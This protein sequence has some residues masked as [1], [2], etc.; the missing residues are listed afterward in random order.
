MSAAQH[1][2]WLNL[3]EKTG[4]FLAVGVLDEAF[5]QGLEKVETRRRQRVRSAYDEWRDAV[6]DGDPQ[7]DGLHREWVRLV[8]E[9]LLEYEPS[10]LKPTSALPATLTYLESLTGAEVKPDFAVLS[11]DKARLLITRYATDTDLSA[12]LAG[13]TWAASPIERMTTLCRATG[14]RVGLITDGEQWTLVSVPA[15]GGSSLGTWYARIWLQEPVTLQAFVSLLEVRRCFGPAEVNL[16]SL[17]LRSLEHQDEVTDT[18][19][20]QV[21]RA[22]E[23]LVQAL[24]R[25]DLD[26]DRE[27]LKDVSP[28]Q[29]YEAGLTVM[30]R[31]VVLLCAEERKL[32]LLGEPIYDQ[33]YAVSTLRARL[34]KDKER[35]G[36]EVLE[37]RHDAWSRLLAVFRAVF[38]GIEHETLRLPPLGGSLFDPDRFPFLEGRATGTSW[39][40]VPAVPLPIDNRTVLMLLTAL[41]VL[42]QRSGA[43]LLSYEALDVEQIGH[44]YEG[45]LERTV[46]R[47]PETTLGLI[48]SQ[49]AINPTIALRELEETKAKGDDKLLTYLL[50]HTGRSESGLKR[51]LT[52]TVDEPLYHRLLL[53]C[54]SDVPL[55]D[56]IKQWSTLVRTDSWGDPLVYRQDA[57]IVTLGAGRRE[58]GTH[59][60]PKSLTEPIVQHT[61]EPL[62]YVGPAEGKPR[63]EWKLKSP[64]QLL[65]LKVC[66]MAM[67][68]GAFLVQTCRWLGE[69]LVEAWDAEEKA[70]RA[71]SIEGVVLAQAGDA[72]PLP[73]DPAERVLIARRLI[74]SRCLYGVDINP[75][76]VELAKLSLWLITMMRNRPFSFLDHALKCGNSLLGIS[77]INQLKNFSLRPGDKQMT[78]ATAN[79]VRYVEEA[80]A[81]RRTLE[82]LPSND[83]AQIEAKQRLHLEAEGA[84]SKVKALANALIAFELRGLNGNE[85][86]EQRAVAAVS[87]ATA[88]Q[89]PLGEAGI[90]SG[91]PTEIL[92]AFHW[93]IEFPEVFLDGGF[94]FTVGNPP[95][96]S[97]HSRQSHKE[98]S[99]FAKRLACCYRFPQSPLASKRLNSAM[100]FWERATDITSPAGHIGLLNDLNLLEEN[101]AVVREALVRH[102]SIL[103]VVPNIKAFK[104]VASGQVFLS[105]KNRPPDSSWKYSIAEGWIEGDR[106][107]QS[108][109]SASNNYD[110]IGSSRSITINGRQLSELCI[111]NT[112]VNLSGAADDFLTDT[113]SSQFSQRFI[114]S[115]AIQSK[116]QS[117][118][119]PTGCI[120]FSEK[121]CEEVN[122]AFRDRG[123]K[124]VAVL[125]KLQ[126]FTGEKIIVRQSASEIIATMDS[127]G[128]VCSYSFFVINKRS[129]CPYD[130]WYILGVLNSRRLTDYAV[131]AGIIKMAAGKQPQIRK[132]GLDSLPIPTPQDENLMSLV[133]V[134]ARKLTQEH[135]EAVRTD[136]F[137]E[138]NRLVEDCF[139]KHSDESVC[140]TT[141]E[142][143]RELELAKVTPPPTRGNPKDKSC[144]PG[145]SSGDVEQSDLL[146]AIFT[147]AARREITDREDLARQVAETLGFQRLT[148]NLREVIASGINSAIRRGLVNYDAQTIHRVAASYAELDHDFLVKAINASIRPGCVY[149]P[150]EVLHLAADYL[151]CKRLKDAFS[152]RLESALTAASLR[153]I[154]IKRGEEIRKAE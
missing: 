100:F 3:V 116:F 53:A 135:D 31:L 36:E 112:G 51:A 122:Q 126:R 29:L 57:F 48:G 149:T 72:E 11:G 28:A 118:I 150:E 67:G 30:M 17:F 83:H 151:G 141:Q 101:F 105:V 139:S 140:E 59:Y 134:L 123:S 77:S 90:V 37:R 107:L 76:A 115:K 62:A 70:G 21:R 106:R 58:T 86:E 110:L 146:N 12:P 131:E 78:F 138:L 18:L 63:D 25:A 121:L 74:A 136:L 88:L 93:P 42:E 34:L 75:M 1:I 69:R 52:K 95:F 97:Y 152:E 143:E 9:E 23:V 43:L 38:G 96:I 50:E 124:N 8:L 91:G 41:Q 54:G 19:G 49:K 5:P 142:P 128:L 132:A 98:G 154:L 44:V 71:I 148:A 133:S 60:T 13:E 92:R 145:R 33:H 45:L 24:D 119:I 117:S 147:C 127:T 84:T 82:A 137:L 55:A 35:L 22:V 27:L 130:I 113:V 32:L 94:S 108:Q 40:D 16:D 81:K 109:L 66:D 102:C 14:V 80:S 103:A 129:D 26:R 73:R 64:A 111:V 2:E 99:D 4:P 87:A 65:A 85:Y 104:R 20:E 144:E 10:V 153:G 39:R 89:S 114:A 120:T 79:L 68:S 6:D 46:K 125:G 15:D 47:V 61:L 56:R 7:L